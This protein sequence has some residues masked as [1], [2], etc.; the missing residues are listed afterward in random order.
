[1]DPRTGRV[2]FHAAFFLVFMS[3]IL[4][5]FLEIGS[6]SSVANTLA[7]L[8]SLAFLLVIIWEVRRQASGL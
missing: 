2:V 3:A 8:I 7:F 6:A 5:F 4:F 1:M